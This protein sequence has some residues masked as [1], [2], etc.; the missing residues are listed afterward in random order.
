M[1]KPATDI[2]RVMFCIVNQ[3]GVLDHLPSISILALNRGEIQRHE[4]I[5]TEGGE[6]KHDPA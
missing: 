5:L 4:T 2:V 6:H 1:R 3:A